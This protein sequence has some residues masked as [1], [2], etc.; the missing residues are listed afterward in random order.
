MSAHIA[1]TGGI[2]SGKSTVSDLFAARGV[3]ILDADLIAREVIAPGTALRAQLFDRFG[4]GIRRADG[5]LDRAAL[6]RIVFDDP[7]RRREL[8]ALLHPAII[9]RTQQLASQANG[10]YQIHVI[11]LLVETGAAD[12]Y[13]RVLVIDCP[14][15]LQLARL[16]AREGLSEREAL[17]ML[18]AQASRTA[19]L[20]IAD[21]VILNDGDSA[22]LEPQVAALHAQYLKPGVYVRGNPQAQ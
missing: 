9:A 3:P 5:E 13:Q 12:R 21:D 6:R 8:E 18:A 15:S 1:L 14:E 10:P 11:P 20:A 16:R 17:A 22:A 2:A 4:P 19:R 7:A